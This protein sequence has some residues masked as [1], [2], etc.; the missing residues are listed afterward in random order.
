MDEPIAYPM[1]ELEF[2]RK[3]IIHEMRKNIWNEI[4]SFNINEHVLDLQKNRNH[5]QMI[6]CIHLKLCQNQPLN[7][8][9]NTEFQRDDYIIY[10][11]I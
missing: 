5:F 6:L 8:I 2:E 4:Q 1:N 11:I 9:Q 7:A 10:N 3:N